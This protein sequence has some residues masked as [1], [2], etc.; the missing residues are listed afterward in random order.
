MGWF[1]AW[2]TID[3]PD[4]LP[5]LFWVIQNAFCFATFVLMQL[6]VLYVMYTQAT[7]KKEKTH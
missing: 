3:P 4:H 7:V 5:D 2:A 6:V 1:V